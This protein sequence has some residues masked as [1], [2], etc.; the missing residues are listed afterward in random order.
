MITRSSTNWNLFWQHHL[1]CW[2]GQWTRY[3]KT[4]KIQETFKSTRSFFANSDCSEIAQIN[5]QKYANGEINTM[6]WSY[7]IDDHSRHDGF[8]HPASTAMR[9]FAFENGAAAWLIPQLQDSQYQ[10]FELFLMQKDIR[11]SVGVL[12]GENGQL[13]H[14]ASVREYRGDSA[15]NNWSVDINQLNP[16]TI[17]GEWQ[18]EKLQINPNLVREP[19][20]TI[21][22]KWNED[23]LKGNQT[24][25]FFPD[26][27]ILRCPKKVLQGRP[28]SI[29]IYWQ[30]KNNQLQI[31]RS[32]YNQIHQLIA[33]SQKT[34]H[35]VANQ[36]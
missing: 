5:Q 2:R 7:S 32:D 29:T 20:Q 22:W 27:I 23:E 6:R 3:S 30:T 26:N 18:G 34:M 15:N 35:R 9:G 33:I 25:H 10:P 8:A 19:I 16:W 12:Y 31:M 14:T 4:G 17:D 21:Q 11:H 28:F 36:S 13:L 24:N 1:G